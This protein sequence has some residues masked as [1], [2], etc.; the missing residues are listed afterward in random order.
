[1]Q[2]QA[3]E[4]GIYDIYRPLVLRKMLSGRKWKQSEY[5]INPKDLVFKKKFC[6][7]FY[8]VET[9]CFKEKSTSCPTTTNLCRLSFFSAYLL[10][11]ASWFAFF[12]FNWLTP[13]NV[14]FFLQCRCHEKIRKISDVP[15]LQH[16]RLQ[17]D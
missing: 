9:V 2:T 10:K 15:A 7:K 17:E 12:F 4:K 11:T 1:M 6:A 14:I 13:T 3:G 16:W 5:F 8:S